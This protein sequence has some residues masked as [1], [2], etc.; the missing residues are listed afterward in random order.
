MK[1]GAITAL[2]LLLP[3][4]AAAQCD[5]GD[6]RG[7]WQ[8]VVQQMSSESYYTPTDYVTDQYVDAG[9]CRIRLSGNTDTVMNVRMNCTNDALFNQG[10]AGQECSSWHQ[11]RQVRGCRWRLVDLKRE[12]RW[13]PYEVW[14]A[15]TAAAL[16]GQST[17]LGDA[18]EGLDS[19]FTG[20][21]E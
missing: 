14:F 12:D 21:R 17:H 18:R 16:V 13:A 1:W 2:A 15:P 7:R 10:C 8:V 4:S 6:I 19:T 11:L 3:A 9:R 5:V 20:V